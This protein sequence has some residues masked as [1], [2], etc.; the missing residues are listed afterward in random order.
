MSD[1]FDESILK[2]EKEFKKR[3]RRI[4]RPSFLGE[5][6]KRETKKPI[7]ITLDPDTNEHIK[8]MQKINL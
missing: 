1:K 4:E 2:D 5:P 6:K 7:P 3:F 8:S